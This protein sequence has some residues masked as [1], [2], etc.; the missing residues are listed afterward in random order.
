MPWGARHGLL[1]V[2]AS[3][4]LFDRVGFRREGLLHHSYRR[5]DGELVDEV[6]FGLTA[7]GRG[8]ANGAAATVGRPMRFDLIGL[9]A[10]DTLWHSEDGFQDAEARFEALV[11]P[12]VDPA[13]DVLD[14][15][16]HV[17]GR[18]M[19]LFGYGVKGFTLSMVECAIEL[20]GGSVP[21]EVVQRIIDEGRRLLERPVRLLPGVAQAVVDLASDHRIV[22][23]TKGDLLHQEMKLAHS[24]LEDHLHGFEVVSEKD[25]ASYAR[26]LERLGVAPGRFLMVGNSVKSDVL[27][28]LAIGGHAVHVPYHV[29]WEHEQVDHDGEVVS[30]ESLADLRAWIDAGR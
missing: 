15:L 12:H 28:V 6:L 16:V 10:D 29:T 8:A 1:G 9:D 5:P 11:S 24:G 18:N 22:V 20:S 23:I 30:I 4:A 21:G 14:H 26:V 3:L 7:D 17:E 19:A 2:D 25:A 13:V 27:P